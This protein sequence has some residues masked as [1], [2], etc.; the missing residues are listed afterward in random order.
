MWCTN[1]DFLSRLWWLYVMF[2]WWSRWG[3]SQMDHEIYLKSLTFVISSDQCWCC[4]HG[5]GGVDIISVHPYIVQRN[6][7]IYLCHPKTHD[8]C[9]CPHGC[10]LK[11]TQCWAHGITARY[12]LWIETWLAMIRTNLGQPSAR[13]VSKMHFIILNWFRSL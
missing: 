12:L 4:W 5:S 7:N 6:R 8:F 3:T 11:T 10:L 9:C 2:C 1:I 13:Q